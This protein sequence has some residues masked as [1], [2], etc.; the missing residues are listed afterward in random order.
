VTALHRELLHLTDHAAAPDLGYIGPTRV[1]LDAERQHLNQYWNK[2]TGVARI[3]G[4][5][6]PHVVEAWVRCQHA[7]RDDHTG[8]EITLLLN[9]SPTIAPLRF[10]AYSTG[11]FVT[12]C[13][14]SN[15]IQNAKRGRYE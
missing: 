13:G 3:C 1:Y 4:G 15:V 6:I 14:L 12:G 10:S 8:G 5:E 9:R 11:L 2:A 7:Y